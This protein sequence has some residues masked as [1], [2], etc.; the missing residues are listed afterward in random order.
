MTEKELIFAISEL[1]VLENFF[2][3]LKDR[4]KLELEELKK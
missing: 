1:E 3:R 2:K 4:Y